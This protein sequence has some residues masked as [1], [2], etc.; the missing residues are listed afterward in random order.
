MFSGFLT[1]GG[2]LFVFIKALLGEFCLGEA[3]F[4]LLSLLAASSEA[5]LVIILLGFF[6]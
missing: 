3:D 6:I 2:Y 4:Y 5:L 1:T